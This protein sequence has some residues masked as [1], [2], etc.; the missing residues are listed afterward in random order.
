MV[1][2]KRIAILG[3]GGVGGYIGGKLAAHFSNSNDVEIVFIAR[4][5]HAEEIRLHGLR[6]I[7]SQ[8]EQIVHPSMITA[9]PEEAGIFDLVI[10]SVKSYD[11][12][13]SIS[14]VN[15]CVGEHTVILPLLNGVD[16]APR[17]RAMIPTAEVWRSEE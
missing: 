8:G 16:A 10:C 5:A 15:P 6:L 13:T 1:S 2:M 3:L 17:I 14:A 12:E 11:L 9:K 4:G 7:T